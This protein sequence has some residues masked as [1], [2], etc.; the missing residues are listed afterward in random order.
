MKWVRSALQGLTAPSESIRDLHE[1]KELIEVASVDDFIGMLLSFPLSPDPE[2]VETISD[3]VYANSKTLDGRRFA[4]QF[5]QKRKADVTS[6]TAAAKPSKAIPPPA[7]TAAEALK[8]R[9]QLEAS[10]PSFKVIQKK[11][12]RK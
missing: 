2:T 12:P 6:G 7:K 10:G 8:S 3:A 4:E 11:K 9:P 5:V 1:A